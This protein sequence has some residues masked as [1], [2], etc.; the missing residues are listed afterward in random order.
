LAHFSPFGLRQMPCRLNQADTA[1]DERSDSP[2][3]IAIQS[4]RVMPAPPAAVSI[5]LLQ[6]L[7]FSA[8]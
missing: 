5:P 8:Q 1:E 4:S 7:H 6:L 2:I 3:C